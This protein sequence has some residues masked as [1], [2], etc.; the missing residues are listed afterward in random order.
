MTSF[1][2]NDSASTLSDVCVSFVG[3]A[4]KFNNEEYGLCN[5]KFSFTFIINIFLN[6]L[7]LLSS[8][9]LSKIELLKF[10]R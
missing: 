5:A 3:K 1:N 4:I 10:G 7:Q 2:L 9:K 6:T 8:S